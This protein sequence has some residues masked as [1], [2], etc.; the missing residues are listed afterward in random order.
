LDK[1][2]NKILCFPKAGKLLS[3]NALLGHFEGG[4]RPLEGRFFP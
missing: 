1:D 2:T 3:L 4:H